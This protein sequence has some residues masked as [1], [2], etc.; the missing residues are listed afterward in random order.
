MG[1]SISE[2]DVYNR[3]TPGQRAE[4]DTLS[5]DTELWQKKKFGAFV[6]LVTM[7]AIFA[8]FL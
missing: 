5:A 7:I 2:S 1:N 4:L 6:A 8:I 3:I